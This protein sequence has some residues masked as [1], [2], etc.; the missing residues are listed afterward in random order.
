MVKSAYQAGD[1]SSIPG[2]A[3]FPRERNGNLLQYSCLGSPI[4]KG[5]W[6]AAVHRVVKESNMT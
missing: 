3:R 1:V 6:W 5:T 2:L 4:D